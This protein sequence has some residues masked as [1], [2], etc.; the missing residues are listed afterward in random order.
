M[1]ILKKKKQNK[2]KL[3]FIKIYSNR[4]LFVCNYIE[5]NCFDK[6][7]KY[8]HSTLSQFIP[9]FTKNGNKLFALNNFLRSM[10][11]LYYNITTNISIYNSYS[12]IDHFMHFYNINRGSK[13][14]S[15][16]L[17]WYIKIYNPIF[18]I[19]C[20]ERPQVLKKKKLPQ[21]FKIL[22]V[23][24]KFRYKTVYKHIALSIKGDQNRFFKDRVDSVITD[25]FFNY[26]KSQLFN[27]KVF[28]YKKFISLS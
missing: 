28:I 22:F 10:A 25:I 16:I 26:K 6:F 13:S 9:Y 11:D 1:K 20:F 8:T 24:E 7:T 21:V 4:A 15:F 3:S 27:R 5:F 17:D 14:P 12:F 23:P 2:I 19:K 18:D